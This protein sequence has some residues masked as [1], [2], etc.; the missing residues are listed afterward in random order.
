M[1]AFVEF[2]DG[3]AEQDDKSKL[4]RKVFLFEIV[5]QV[6]FD[7]DMFIERFQNEAKVELSKLDIETAP[8]TEHQ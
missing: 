5:E 1:K 3:V 8:F 6:G 2:F 7:R 4:Q